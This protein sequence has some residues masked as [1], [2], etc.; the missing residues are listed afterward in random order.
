MFSDDF[1][2]ALMDDLNTPKA[3]AEMFALASDIEE[4]KEEEDDEALS[5]FINGGL[6]LGLFY[7]DPEEWFAAQKKE[8][9]VDESYIL[10]QIEKRAQ[11]KKNK[12]FALADKIR[13]DLAAQGIVLKDS[14][15]GTSWEAA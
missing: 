6:L 7:N 1:I 3:M 2:N 5:N 8:T 13:D 15:E 4:D 12:D 14:P 9:S 10:E 11:A